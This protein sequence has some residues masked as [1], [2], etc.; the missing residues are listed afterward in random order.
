MPRGPR[1]SGN[2]KARSR[3][4]DRPRFAPRIVA[5]RGASAV[6]PENTA[7]AFAEALRLRADGIELDLQLT[8]DGVPVVFHDRSLH[9]LGARGPIR[10]RTL[11]ELRALDFGAW[12][13]AE[14]VGEPI[15]T[16]TGVLDRFGRRTELLLELKPE[17]ETPA[18]TRVLVD[19]VIGALARSPEARVRILCFD[20]RVLARVAALAPGLPRVR[21]ID[22]RPVGA[23][24]TAALRGVAAL[25]LPARA[26]DAE[27]VA[28][29]HGRGRELWVYRCDTLRNLAR[30]RSAGVDGIITDRPDW[31]RAQLR[32]QMG[33]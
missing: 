19:A 2:K 3:T 23:A 7:S 31:L 16:L 5:H 17:G 26:V 13:G 8:R 29:A 27:L 21:N 25:C 32:A 28:A 6:R 12:F 11:A 30:V 18:R 10:D 4:S 15:P 33:G 1:A 24:L 9:K 22:R 20:P 14:H